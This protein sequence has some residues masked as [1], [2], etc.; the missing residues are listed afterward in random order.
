MAKNKEEN[1]KRPLRKLT[2][3]EI[4]SRKPTLEGRR[5]LA[6]RAAYERAY[7]E[8]YAKRLKQLREELEGETQASKTKAEPQ[9]KQVQK[10]PEQKLLTVQELANR[11]G[12]PVSW[13]YRRTREK[14][15]GSMPAMRVGKYRRFE[16]PKVLEWL[17]FKEKD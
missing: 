5:E 14:G 9:P 3:R 12:V 1:Y 13:V 2:T 6:Y 11:L 8:A 4:F 17:A 16:L 7:E 15:P 10:A